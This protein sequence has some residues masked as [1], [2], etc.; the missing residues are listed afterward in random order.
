MS[1]VKRARPRGRSLARRYRRMAVIGAALLVLVTVAVFTKQNPF[2]STF[3]VRAVF[4]SAAQLHGGGEVRVAGIHVGQVDAIAPGPHN[5][6]IVTMGINQNGLPIHTDATL[7]I[8]PRLIL[9]GNAYVDLNPGTV[10][11]AD[12]RSGALVPGSQTAISVQIDQLLDTFN[13]PTRDALQSSV[14][15]LA[16]GLSGSSPGRATAPALGWAGLRDAVRQFDGALGPAT[17]VAQ[18]AQGSQPGDLGR[19]VRSSSDVTAQLAE[20]PAALADIVTSYNTTFA[21]LASQDQALA[22]SISGFDAVLRVAPQP[23]RQLDA[24][25]PTLTSFATDLRPA[26]HAAPPALTQANG[27]LSQVT[28]IVRPAELPTLLHRLGP[29]LSS[30]PGLETRLV[31]LFG[32]STPVT[33]CI[34]THVVPALSMK[35]PDGKLSTG[36]PA[37]LD[38]VHLF[39]GLTS[40]SSSVDGNGGTARMGLTLGNQNVNEILPGVGQIVGRTPGADGVRPTW[41]GY[42]VLPPFRPDQQCANQPLPNLS[43]A[44]G[45]APAWAT[46]AN[47]APVAAPAPGGSL[48]R[49]SRV[50]R[51]GRTRRSPGSAS[52]RHSAPGPSKPGSPAPPAT[53]TRPAPPTTQANPSPTTPA[54]TTPTTTQPPPVVSQPGGTASRLLHF[55]L[56]R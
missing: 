41:L 46:G 55:L 34:S 14:A 24:A 23:L 56:G 53:T 37:Y 2:A 3:A 17:Q 54:S 50:T 52:G 43:E 29:V 13:L 21:A 44:P 7:T 10:A 38:L 11:A 26:L 31:T 28:A 45:A 6:A 12:L 36:D 22:N 27:L 47:S 42:G 1:N 25:L 16:T 5:T 4:S 32:Y 9:E 39:T 20:S 51:K 8:K 33:S 30:L 15:A 35:V 18:A 48:A 19:A 40:F 49:A